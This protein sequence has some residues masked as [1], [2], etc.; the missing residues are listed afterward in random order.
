MRKRWRD[1]PAFGMWVFVISL[2]V[3]LGAFNIWLGFTYGFWFFNIPVGL[4][5]WGVAIW[6]WRSRVKFMHTMDEIDARKAR[7]ERLLRRW[8]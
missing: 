3:V 6:S 7:N 4:A 1:Y 5:V 2:D 8:I